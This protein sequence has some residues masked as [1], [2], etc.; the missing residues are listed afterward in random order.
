MEPILR[1]ASEARSRIRSRAAAA[2]SVMQEYRASPSLTSAVTASGTTSCSSRAAA[3]SHSERSRESR[4]SPPGPPSSRSRRP[5][6]HSRACSEFRASYSCDHNP[7][8]NPGP[9][10]L[11]HECH[12]RIA[13]IERHEGADIADDQFCPAVY[14]RGRKCLAAIVAIPDDYLLSASVGKA[15]HRRVNFAGQQLS[16]LAVLW[17]CLLLAADPGHAFPI[18]NHEDGLLGLTRARR[19][20]RKN[21]EDEPGRIDS[22]TIPHH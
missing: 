17:V 2:E 7:S 8:A 11:S 4:N 12:S 6:Y 10:V 15:I 21:E 22:H 1:A 19:H 20:R 18:A 13:A 5:A 16:Q 9:A 3:W 14:R